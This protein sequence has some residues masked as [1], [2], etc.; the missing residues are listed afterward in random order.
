MKRSLIMA[1]ALLWQLVS[2]ADIATDGSLGSKQQLTGPHYHISQKLGTQFGENLFH[3]FKHF[4]LSQGESA[5]FSGSDSIRH[6]IN[7]VTGGFSQIDGLI[8]SEVGKAD[9]YFIN[10]S[11]IVFGDHAHLDVPAAFYVSTASQLKLADGGNFDARSPANSHLTLAAP[12]AF[13]FTTKQAGNMTID[14]DGLEFHPNTVAQFSANQLTV[15]GAQIKAPN[16]V[17]QIIATGQV[18]QD[19]PVGTLN[20]ATYQGTL[21]VNGSTI[22]VSGNGAGRLTIRAKQMTTTDSELTVN[23]TGDAAMAINDGIDIRVSDLNMLDSS[24]ISTAYA[25]GI[26]GS[27][28][29]NADGQLKAKGSGISSDSYAAGDAGSV[30]VHAKDIWLDGNGKQFI[31][32]IGSSN[33]IG[34]G[35]AG[36]INVTTKDKLT[37]VNGAVIASGSFAQGNAGSVN[38]HAGELQVK[39]KKSW[40]LFTGIVSGTLWFST[41]ASGKVK[42][43]VDGWL[44]LSNGG[45]ISSGTNSPSDADQVI[46]E[47]NNILI[48]GKNKRT[49]IS[50]NAELYS[51]GNAGEI[52][53]K[54]TD[55]LIILNGG[56][57]SSTTFGI[58]NAGHIT[59]N[60]GELRIDGQDSNN[61]TGITTSSPFLASGNAGSIDVKVTDKLTLS[62]NSMI[63]SDT[64]SAGNAGQVTVQANRVFIDG[65]STGISSAARSGASGSVGSITLSAQKSLNLTHG[66]FIH[67]TSDTI[68]RNPAKLSAKRIEIS[69]PIIELN[70]AASISAAATQNM[71]ASEIQISANSLNIIDSKII[72]SAHKGDGG[73]ISVNTQNWMQL[74]DSQITTSVTGTQGDGGNIT[75]SAPVLV[76]DTGF[77]QA[78][79]AATNAEGGDIDLT[80]RQ[81]VT[82]G[83]QL[84]LGGKLPAS[85]TVNS[86]ENVVQ[87]AAPDGIDGAIEVSA[88]QLNIT[89]GLIRLSVPTLTIERLGQDPC[90]AVIRGNTLKNLGRG[91]VPEFHKGQDSQ[92]LQPLLSPP[93]PSSVDPAAL[94]LPSTSDDCQLAKVNSNTETVAFPD[95]DR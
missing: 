35:N 42:V 59:V 10:P 64:Q 88:P 93:L 1:L 80:L 5:T 67:N 26:A 69:A 19:V 49:G 65:K 38:V 2:Q 16:G 54:A 68:T 44:R 75:I 58:G 14:A 28:K 94:S 87:A 40:G 8:R 89:G 81:L 84:T 63:V 21:T 53:V 50:S 39:G 66:G 70:D 41:G 12:E 31:Y 6:V 73:A 85:F 15:N 37:L 11:G 33:K 25:A 18:A 24:I 48:D 32:G 91:G 86:G 74:R 7:R 9:F 95:N 72:T 61:F 43:K 20:N 17:L 3:S 34:S 83:A 22:E 29:I 23:N 92:T 52:F 77:I 79:T 36:N 46:V 51:K 30:E 4:N 13:G 82:N 56:G 27:V 60:A 71:P 62:N 47:A 45:V 57:I 55:R 76:L 90:S 78:N